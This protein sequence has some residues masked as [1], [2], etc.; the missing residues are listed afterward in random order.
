M[1]ST[2]L[3]GSISTGW[4]RIGA[5]LSVRLLLSHGSLKCEWRPRLPTPAELKRLVT[6][7]GAVRDGFTREVVLQATG[8]KR[9]IASGKYKR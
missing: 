9:P 5:G 6:R 3:T 2:A 8:L 1:R 4:R 7:Y